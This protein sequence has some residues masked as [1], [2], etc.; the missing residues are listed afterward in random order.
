MHVGLGVLANLLRRPQGERVG[1][2]GMKVEVFLEMHNNPGGLGDFRTSLV[3]SRDRV[4][5]SRRLSS[6]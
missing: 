1:A 2:V 5:G 6:S 3:V 4:S